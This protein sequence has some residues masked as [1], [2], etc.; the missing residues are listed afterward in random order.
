MA[1]QD[2][3]KTGHPPRLPPS[4][5]P[6]IADFFRNPKHI[7]V[8]SRRTQISDEDLA[9]GTQLDPHID[10]LAVFWGDMAWPGLVETS[11]VAALGC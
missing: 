2:L 4:Q 9:R 10:P 3:K 7:Q 1:R 11:T 6:I 5:T 8:M